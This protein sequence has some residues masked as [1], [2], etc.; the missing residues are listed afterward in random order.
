MKGHLQLLRLMFHV[1]PQK[2]LGGFLV[3]VIDYLL[4][5]LS[6]IWLLR[7]VVESIELERDF[8]EV[9]ERLGVIAIIYGVHLLLKCWYECIL[10]DDGKIRLRE[11]LDH[12]LFEQASRMD[13]AQ[14]ENKEYY[15]L[16]SRAVYYVNN[17]TELIFI[18]LCNMVGFSVMAISSGVILFSIDRVLP[19]FA[20]LCIPA[21]LAGCKFILNNGG[22]FFAVILFKLLVGLDDGDDTQFSGSGCTVHDFRRA[23]GR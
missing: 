13:I 16:F 9:L 20:F 1:C 22:T 6:S 10:K 18:N 3:Q 17:T 4:E 21:A 8:G 5:T 15:T 7:F 12:A 2:L 11:E 19:L 14:Y 23:D